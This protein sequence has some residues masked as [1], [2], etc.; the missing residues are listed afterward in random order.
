MKSPRPATRPDS[1]KISG[2]KAGRRPARVKPRRLIAI[3]RN[4]DLPRHH[5][6]LVLNFPE[7][8]AHLE[9]TRRKLVVQA[10]RALMADGKLSLRR[11]AGALNI[12]PVTL[13]QWLANF[14]N[15]GEAGLKTR[16]KGHR[17]QSQH[18]TMKLYLKPW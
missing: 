12:A 2:D 11:A 16:P 13:W 18:C 10:A 4:F 8:R 6:Y 7:V 5:Q 9:W 1:P 3:E 14:E 17:F 15:H